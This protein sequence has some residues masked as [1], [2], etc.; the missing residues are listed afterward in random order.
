M[1][2]AA[3]ATLPSG[4]PLPA[5]LQTYLIWRW[6]F[7]YLQA[8]RRRYGTR[9][10][11]NITSHPPLV[12]L[13]NPT[14]IRAVLTAP[15]DVLHP[16]EGAAT[17]E[18]L[19]GDRSFMLQES[20][21]HLCGRRAVLR[22]LSVR[23]LQTQTERLEA[24]ASSEVARWPR[25]G[26]F[27]LHPHLRR[28]TLQTLLHTVSSAT[29]PAA[30]ARVALL[31]ERLLEMLTVTAS[32]VLPEPLLRH[33]P[34]LRT[35]KRFLADRVLVDEL[36]YEI[37]D[38][39]VRC[40][41]HPGDL[42]DRLLAATNPDGA[43]SSPR[44]V[45]DNLMSIILAGHETTASQLAWGFQLLAHN[46]RVQ[47]RVIEELDA[48]QG[49]DYLT[50]TV[51]EILRHRPV[52]L[53]AIPRAV[54]KPIEISGWRYERPAHL[55]GCIYLLHHDPVF[56]PQPDEFRPERFLGPAPAPQP[57][58]PW[59]GG[60]KRCPGLHLATLEIETVLR[61]VLESMTVEPASERIERPRWR[62]VIVTPHAGSRV[63]LRPRASRAAR[64][65][66]H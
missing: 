54:N 29:E 37:I 46:P 16:G 12:F 65:T 60:R 45:R 8:C 17:I 40:E 23:A 28:L 55:L 34:G 48:G 14:E 10:T 41:D 42:L 9:F 6:P 53:F 47:A 56:Y 39:R 49:G 33:G 52:F 36:L 64:V 5:P 59:G 4:P 44:Q 13:S 63:I 43:P 61:I 58:L 25:R 7:S 18:S 11:T 22:P 31:R 32:A 21:Q 62:S 35:W 3:R 20:E 51:K 24:I 2:C 30:R 38:D 50:A 66:R 15:A 26:A 27:A 19:V 57:W 1:R